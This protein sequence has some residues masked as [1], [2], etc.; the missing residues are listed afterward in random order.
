MKGIGVKTAQ[1]VIVDLKD[2]IKAGDDSLIIQSTQTS[3]AYD[4]ALAALLMLGFARQQSQK[5]LKKLFDANP[6]LKVEVAIKQALSM[7]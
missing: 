6:A 1:R 3:D 2:K 4:E 5:V 7:L